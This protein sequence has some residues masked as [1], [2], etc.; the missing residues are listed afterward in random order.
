M[1]TFFLRSLLVVVV[2][3]VAAPSFAA[4][5]WLDVA[6][7]SGELNGANYTA[8]VQRD[9]FFPDQTPGYGPGWENGNYQRFRVLL[10]S[11]VSNAGF[12]VQFAAYRGPTVIA[13]AEANANQPVTYQSGPDIVLNGVTVKWQVRTNTIPGNSN[14][15]TSMSDVVSWVASGQSPPPLKDLH[16]RVPANQSQVTVTY[17]LVKKSDGSTVGGPWIM[18]PGAPQSDVVVSGLP[19]DATA[20]DYELVY[21]VDGYALEDGAWKTVPLGNETLFPTGVQ[22]SQEQLVDAGTI[23]TVDQRVTPQAPTRI[24]VA[25]GQEPG[26]GTGVWTTGPTGTGATDALTNRVYREGVDKIVA[27]L[28]AQLTAAKAEK[29]ERDQAKEDWKSNTE[30]SVQALANTK[31][32]EAQNAVAAALGNTT[33]TA[34]TSGGTSSDSIYSIPLAGGHTVSIA[35]WNDTL[36]SRGAAVIKAFITVCVFVLFSSWMLKEIRGN[37]VAVAGAPQARGN[38]VAGTGGQISGLIAAA[39]VTAVI[40]G[41]PVALAGLADNGLGWKTVQDLVTPV[42]SA[43]SGIGQATV[44][45]FYFVCPVAT[46]IAAVAQYFVVRASG[47]VIMVGAMVAIRW[48]VPVVAFALACVPAD[49]WADVVV[50]NARAS[51][52]V[53]VSPADGSFGPVVVPAGVEQAVTIAAGSVYVAEHPDGS[54]STFEALDGSR[55]AL[56]ENGVVQVATPSSVWVAMFF[57][58]FAVGVVFELFGLGLRLLTRAS[59]SQEGV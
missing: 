12:L 2:A 29:A 40:L 36:V 26:E 5:N 52:D 41:A 16:V 17:R 37:M 18:G 22:P 56:R 35:P 8:R 43:G 53:A 50:R 33:V 20:E 11:T 14:V 39:V 28:D 7:Y 4:E 51:G 46:V 38:T 25:P 31:K 34:G 21:K 3:A 45:L 55:V 59:G 10:V 15:W 58:G 48:I 24:P 19:A 42:A 44:D 9:T 6:T 30:A 54:W 23:P 13:S 1:N 27:K 49:A 57:R 47:L 32:T